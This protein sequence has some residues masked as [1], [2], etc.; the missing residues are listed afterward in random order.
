MSASGADR[1]VQLMIS[2]RQ[3]RGVRRAFTLVELLVV[4]GIITILIGILIP[5]V[6]K[7]RTAARNASTASFIS[8]LSSAID[9]YY[10]DYRSYP[11]PLSNLEVWNSSSPPAITIDTDPQITSQ[12]FATVQPTGAGAFREQITMSENLVLGLL[13]GLKYQ[14]S[15]AGIFY[16]PRLVGSGANSLN[17]TGV[18]K[19]GK[20]YIDATNL[21][22]RKGDSAA[23]QGR[24]TGYYKDDA[25]SAMD[26]LIPEFLDQYNDPMPILYLRAKNGASPVPEP[27][28][29]TA[30]DNV[31]GI[32]TFH[33]TNPN[34]R[35]GQY[36]V[37]QIAGYV[38]P[39]ASSQFSI[40][41][42]KRKIDYYQDSATPI[43]TP[44]KPYHGLG[45][46]PNAVRAP[47]PTAVLSPRGNGYYYPYNA[48]PYFRNKSLSTPQTPI[49]HQK[50][51][52]I[53]ISAGVDRI[54]GTDDDITN[55]GT[56]GK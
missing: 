53:L 35:N 21:S 41:E 27:P 6:G 42:G 8:Q 12:G 13:G 15:P 47:D 56:I 24:T 17:S 5:V 16:D 20:A 40:G 43:A 31:N 55:F 25:A 33:Q 45:G 50:D 32:I 48:Y 19:R 54:Y 3:T 36:D 49:P 26:T 1:K 34:L 14:T 23:D 30:T 28:T 51:G 39:N 18:T 22:W 38:L 10:Q 7:V 2:S 4:I 29:G 9:A 52:Y 37:H 44:A 11:G 46:G